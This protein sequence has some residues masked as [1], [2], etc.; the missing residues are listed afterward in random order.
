MRHNS[1]NALVSQEYET[2]FF[3]CFRWFVVNVQNTSMRGYS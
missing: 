2:I 3:F 1:L